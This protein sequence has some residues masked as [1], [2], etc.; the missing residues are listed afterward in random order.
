MKRSRKNT[1]IRT[2]IVVAKVV[3]MVFRP[4]YYP[5]L[6][7]CILFTLTP[8]NLL[9]LGHKLIELAVMFIFTLALPS[10]LCIMYRRTRHI[11]YADM[12]RR[13]NRLVPY[14]IFI[15]CYMGYLY[16]MHQASV[17]YIQ[18]S[19]I[20]V[21]LLIQIVCTILCVWWKVSVHA[22]GAGAIIS[23]V[24]VYGAVFQFNPLP[25]MSIAIILAGMVGTSRM[26]LRQHSLAQVLVGTFIG[27]C[28]GFYGIIKGYL[29]FLI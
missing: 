1:E 24:A 14:C 23:A 11:E 4:I 20:I 16:L 7:T 27:V 15:V 18:I 25:W 6:C 22:A 19:V 3:S 26:L 2:L 10:F 8:L 21:A 12:R 28:C 29:F 5:L 9:P 13:T 17:P